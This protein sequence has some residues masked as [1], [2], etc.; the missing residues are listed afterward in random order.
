MAH[1]RSFF[2]RSRSRLSRHLS[3]LPWAASLRTF[4]TS[5]VS[6][7]ARLR[8]FDFRPSSHPLVPLARWYFL[9]FVFVFPCWN[10]AI[11]GLYF[12]FW[13]NSKLGLGCVCKCANQQI[14]RPEPRGSNLP[15]VTC[16]YFKNGEIDCSHRRQ[17]RVMADNTCV[18]VWPLEAFQ[19]SR[20]EIIRLRCY[21][22]E[23]RLRVL[24]EVRNH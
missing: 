21:T 14:A 9:L 16:D 1:V 11:F 24:L 3:S 17:G 7:C 15:E 20:G 8:C 18:V 4:T 22:R 5:L 12:L 13:R 2:F 10:F 19:V 6:V 23:P